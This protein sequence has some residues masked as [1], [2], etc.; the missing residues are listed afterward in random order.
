MIGDAH[1]T[2]FL[3]Q[4]NPTEDLMSSLFLV[5]THVGNISEQ[6]DSI[7]ASLSMFKT[8]ISSL[9]QQVRVLDKIVKKK[10]NT[11]IYAY[12]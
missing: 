9:H 11:I 3:C 4:L 7:V 2:D 6:F 5:V 1:P 8:H 12:T 10:N